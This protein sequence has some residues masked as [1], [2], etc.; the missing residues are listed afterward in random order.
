M[1]DIRLFRSA[2]MDYETAAMIWR[3]LY[4][5][6]MILNNA[7]YHLQQTVEKVLKGALECVG[8]TV[9]NTHKISKLIRMIFDHG[10][11]L[12]LTDWIDDHSE[13]LSEWE[14]QTRYDMDFLVE[15]RKLD[16]AMAEVE[17]FLE[18]NGIQDDLREELRDFSMKEKLLH[19]LPK[20][21][22]ECS[23]FELNCYY[24]MFRK[25]IES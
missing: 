14:A 10:A 16:T 21:K 20:S 6:E 25:K 5:D 8:V 9:P 17:N 13:M 3:S 1:C 12:I 24:I 11:N 22:R 7:A 18:V 19:C 15:K 4:N 2:R 23:D